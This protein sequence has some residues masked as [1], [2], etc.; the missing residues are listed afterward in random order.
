VKR[1]T[2]LRGALVA[3]FTLAIAAVSPSWAQAPFDPPGLDRAMA[4]KNFHVD[5]LLEIDGVV[6]VGVGLTAGGQAAVVIAT[7]GPGVGGLPR[8]LDGVPVVIRVTGT[9]NAINKPDAN[10]E[11]DHGGTTEETTAIDPTGRFDRPVP[12]GVS[13]GN[14]SGASCSAGTIGFRV[15]GGGDVFALSNNHVYALG[16]DD[17][18]G[19][20]NFAALGD[21]IVQPGLFDSNCDG[22]GNAIGTLNDY[23]PLD[24]RSCSNGGMNTVD[25][26]IAS[27]GGALGN[28]TP[29]DEYAPSSTSVSAYAGMNVQKYGRTTGLTKG[30]VAAINFDVNIGYSKG[31]ACFRDQIIVEGSKGPFI[32]AGDSGSGLVTDD[33]SANPVGLLFAGNRSGTVAIANDIGEVLYELRVT[34]D[35]P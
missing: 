30:S 3:I 26:A 9:F 5:G 19:D 18:S 20:N 33:E 4:A 6:G 10:G 15:T 34:V 25:A 29:G 7:E 12:I 14:G 1:S 21:L 17:D 8:S 2:F 27:V 32:K 11:H 13:T 28:A 23:V 31:T 35:G 22:E 24:L 16:N